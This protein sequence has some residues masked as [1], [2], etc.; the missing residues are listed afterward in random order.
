MMGLLGG[1]ADITLATDWYNSENTTI[2]WTKWNYQV[3]I[4]LK[5]CFFLPLI[6]MGYSKKFAAVSVGVISGIL[7]EY[8]VIIWYLLF[9]K[10]INYLNF[11]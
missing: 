11:R 8:L 1:T 3:H 9:L 7:H 5:E 2:F 6:Q 10:I 4:W